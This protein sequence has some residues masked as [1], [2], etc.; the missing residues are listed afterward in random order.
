MTDQ[1][2]HKPS[3]IDLPSNQPAEAKPSRIAFSEPAQ[4]A[5]PVPK[6]PS[7]ITLPSPPVV[8]PQAPK[9]AHKITL[10]ETVVT[11]TVL[12]PLPAPRVVQA[13]TPPQS[14]SQP[15]LPAAP[16]ED[17]SKLKSPEQARFEK[18]CRRA[19]EINPTA[20]GAAFSSRLQA[21]LDVPTSSWYDW[22]QK[23]LDEN[24]RATD[25]FAEVSRDLALLDVT[26]W[27]EETK[28][29]AVRLPSFLERLTA[30]PPSY[31]E[32]KLQQ[33][34]GSL[35]QLIK[36][37]DP[38]VSSLSPVVDRFILDVLALQVASEGLTKPLDIQVADSRL[39][40]LLGAQQSISVTLQGLENMKATIVQS[41]QTIDM[42]LTQTIP[43]WNVAHAKLK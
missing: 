10:P 27:I 21:L 16:A 34:R 7:R 3:R 24:K 11:Q 25:R 1:G 4:E 20:K 19:Q 23:T 9:A 13:S 2:D 18:L 6:A 14:V 5:A 22:G 42:L 28:E 8:E 26:K 29:A 32:A 37:L 40:V 15:A 33:I 35:D 30:K 43:Q 41:I 38:C 12:P 36:Q 39:R 17:F 31:Y